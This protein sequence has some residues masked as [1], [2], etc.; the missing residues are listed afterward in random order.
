MS[1]T[2]CGAAGEKG[3]ES[4]EKVQVEAKVEG[5]NGIAEPG[6]ELRG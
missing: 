6:I 1:R 2:K 5:K 4:R 3:K